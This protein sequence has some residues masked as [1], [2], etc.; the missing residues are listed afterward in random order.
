MEAINSTINL[1]DVIFTFV[2]LGI[3]VILTVA[4]VLL[5]RF[6]N[7]RKKQIDRLEEKL[8]NDQK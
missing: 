5:I 6:N 3:F 1:G 2:L 4:I 7:K 8:E